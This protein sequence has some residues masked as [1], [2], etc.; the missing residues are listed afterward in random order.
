[1]HAVS[2]QAVVDS[3]YPAVLRAAAA[4]LMEHQYLDVG[5]F[6]KE[7][8]Q[9]DL[10]DLAMRGAK[11]VAGTDTPEDFDVLLV[12]SCM[13]LQAEGGTLDGG[14]EKRMS[15]TIILLTFEDLARKGVIEFYREK[16]TLVNEDLDVTIAR[17]KD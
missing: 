6:L 17:V 7:L 1:M 12:L 5:S 14:V 15:N 10:D 11:V 8:P 9:A 13:L 2:F 16:A 3:K 4:K